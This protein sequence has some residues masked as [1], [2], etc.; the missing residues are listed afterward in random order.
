MSVLT[1]KCPNCGGYLVFEPE[2]QRYTCPYCLSDFAQTELASATSES[3]DTQE[4]EDNIQEREEQVLV[5]TCPS[6]GAEIA[7]DTTTA[8]TFCYYC[9]NPVVLSK[10]LGGEQM[11]S[12]IV[13]FQLS[14]EEAKERFLS[15]IGNK[16]YIP[17]AFYSPAQIEK[18]SGI[19]FPYW[20]LDCTLQADMHATA[21]DIRIW[22]SC[23]TEYTETKTYAI[24]R[25]GDISLTELSRNALQKS[26]SKMLEG[27]LP[28]DLKKACPFHPGYLS[29]FWAEVKDIEKES[30]LPELQEEI[31]HYAKSLIS[32]TLSSHQNVTTDSF[33]TY[34]LQHTWKYLLLPVW[35]LTYSHQGKTYYFAMNG[36]TGEICGRLPLHKR[37]LFFTC[38]GIFAAVTTLITL[39]G[40]FLLC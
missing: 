31:N 18:L 8:A 32:N 38:A 6:C 36:Q 15:W 27:I 10:R 14:K 28:F 35:I 5:Y 25:L 11:P 34:N 37:K 29:G 4:T 3:E 16:A 2:T 1:Y 20:T 24:H 13:P 19:Y 23:D 30:L 39:I 7:T 9:H 33:Q 21:R 26:Q 17:P 12:L 40:G 22:R